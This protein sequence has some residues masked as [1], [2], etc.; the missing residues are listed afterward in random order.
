MTAEKL[1]RIMHLDMDAF[2]ASIEQVDNPA[3]SGKPVIVGGDSRGVV[4]AA[5]YEARKFGIR[6]AMPIFQ[7]R[8]LCPHGI[9]LPVRMQRYREA[10]RQVMEILHR[11]SPLVEQISID[12]AFLDITGTEMLHGSPELLAAR[13]K[14][15]IHAVTSLTC[16]VGIAPGK[17]LAKIASEMKKPD[18]LSVIQESDLPELLRSLPV[19]CIPGIGAK[20][21]EE[22]KQ[23]GIVVASDI[24]RFPPAWISKAGKNVIRLY[25]FVR[26][27]EKSPVVPEREPR[28][29]GA[30][31]TFP[32][33]LEDIR[34]IKKWLLIQSERVGRELR[35]SGYCAKTLSLKVKFSDFHQIIRSKT[36]HTPTSSS[37][38]IFEIVCGLLEGLVLAKKV[39]LTGISAS[40]LYS[41]MD[42]LK[43]FMDKKLEREKRLDQAMDTIQG[44][45]GKHALVRGRI[46]ACDE[47]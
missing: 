8:R 36:L 5:S 44:R 1:R 47:Q 45:Y 32:A 9:F 24:L 39:R 18:G 42:Q 31:N 23:M 37:G 3:L 17:V 34:A 38:I 22:L 2:Y 15:E 41:G 27:E 40:Q 28:S 30:E 46:F 7:A 33:D 26:G 10:S 11:Y 4:S 35:A 20:A 43:L 6:S 13:I 12:E 25:E 19:A 16:S 21:A 14:R 29:I